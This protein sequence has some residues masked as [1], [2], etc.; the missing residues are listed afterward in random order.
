MAFYEYKD[1]NTIEKILKKS[2]STATSGKTKNL[3]RQFA[4]AVGNSVKVGEYFKIE[5]RNINV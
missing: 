4:N 2:V 1:G 5:N 3:V